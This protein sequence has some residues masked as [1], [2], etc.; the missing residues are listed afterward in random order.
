LSE[1]PEDDD[2]V[3]KVH[4][5]HLCTIV[6]YL[7]SRK[8]LDRLAFEEDLSCLVRHYISDVHIHT[9]LIDLISSLR[10]APKEIKEVA[11]GEGFSVR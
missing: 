9:I 8:V 3:K 11:L 4:S 7:G 2:G 10:A 5:T 1:P 6:L